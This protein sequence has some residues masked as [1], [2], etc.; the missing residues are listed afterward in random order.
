MHDVRYF[1]RRLSLRRATST[2]ASAGRPS[3][4]HALCEY[5]STPRFIIHLRLGDA[6][7][8]MCAPVQAAAARVIDAGQQT[9]LTD[10]LI[11]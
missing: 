6:K 3:S 11:K 8:T 10:A 9:K 5:R 2:G 1:V 7:C 4:Q